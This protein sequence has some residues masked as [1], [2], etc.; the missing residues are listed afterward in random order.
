MMIKLSPYHEIFFNEWKLNPNRSD[1]NIVIDNDLFGV[2]DPIRLREALRRLSADYLLLHSHIAETAVGFCWVAQPEITSAFDYVDAPLSEAELFSY[3]KMPF[4]LE[5]GPLLRVCLI[6]IKKKH[7]RMI[8]VAHHLIMDGAKVKFIFETIPLYYNDDKHQFG[9]DISTQHQK[10]NTLSRCLENELAV[11]EEGHIKFWRAQLSGLSGADIRFLKKAQVVSQEKIPNNPIGE[12]LFSLD[13]ATD[14]DLRLLSK[15]YGT[16][17]YLFSQAIFATLL[18]RYTAQNK[19]ALC[20]LVGLPEGADFIY[21]VHVSPVIIPYQFSDD[22][23]FTDILKNAKNY[24]KRVKA[25][26]HQYFPIQRLLSDFSHNNLLTIGFTQTDLK[27]RK[28]NFDG[29]FDAS[30]NTGLNIDCSGKLLFAQEDRDGTHHYRVMYDKRYI[31]AGLLEEFIK[32]YKKLFARITGSF[33]KNNTEKPLTY[34]FENFF[35]YPKSVF[36]ELNK[37]TLDCSANQTLHQLFEER[38]R[39]IPD[40]IALV[41][42]NTKLTYRALNETANRLAHTLKNQYL[43]EPDNRIGLCLNRDSS[44]IVAVLAILKTGAAYVPIDPDYPD[45]RIQYILND[46]QARCVVTNECFEARLTQLFD[47]N[48]LGVF[49]IDAAQNQLTL[50]MQPP[51]N[52][53]TNTALNHLAYVIYTSGTTGQPKGVMIEHRSVINLV[54]AQAARFEMLD[55]YMHCLSVAP[56]VFDAHVSEIFVPLCYGHRVHLASDSLRKDMLQLS[57]YIKSNR[58]DI[59]TIP[60]AL[61]NKSY[62]LPLKILIVA[63]EKAE[64]SIVDWYLENGVK[65]INGYGP[66]E[67]TVCVTSHSYQ[68]GDIAANIGKPLANTQVYVLDAQLHLLPTSAIGELYIGGI[69]LARGYL[70]KPELTAQKF[71]PNPFQDELENGQ[72]FSGRLYKT[73]DLVRCLANG[74]L[75][76]LGRMDDQIKVRGMRV[77]LAEIENQLVH[78]PAIHTAVVINQSDDRKLLIAY[79]VSCVQ[80]EESKLYSYLSEKLPVHMLPHAFIHMQALPVTLQG[81]LDKAALPQP[82]VSPN[83]RY[84]APQNEL[85]NIVCCVYADILGLPKAAVGIDHDFFELGGDSIAAIRLVA[86][87]S[88]YLKVRINHIFEFKTPKKLIANLSIS[89]NSFENNIEN[90]KAM[91]ANTVQFF[92]NDWTVSER[93]NLGKKEVEYR[94]RINSIKFK[95]KIKNIEGVLLTGSTGHLGCNLLEKLLFETNYHIYLPVRADSQALAYDR[96]SRKF[97]YYF[98]CDLRE[99]YHHR[100]TLFASDLGEANLG[101]CD[102]DYQRL[103]DHVDSIIHCAALIKHQGACQDFYR[104]NVQAT[105]NLLE[106]AKLTRTKDFHYI[107]T[108]SVLLLGHVPNKK[109]FFFTEEDDAQILVHSKNNYVKT[110]HQAEILIGQYRGEGVQGNIYRVGNQGMHSVTHKWQENDQDSMFFSHIKAMI[111]FGEIPVEISRFEISPVD[112]TALAIVRLFRQEDIKNQIHHVFSPYA[113]DLREVLSGFPEFNFRESTLDEF[114]KKIYAKIQTNFAFTQSHVLMVYQAL[115][116]E[117]ENIYPTKIR[118][119]Q[120]KTQ[121]YLSKLNFAWPVITAMMFFEYIRNTRS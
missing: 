54:H 81:K 113:C 119:S 92:E 8:I 95:E 17:P 88:V 36:F 110:K 5:A 64:Q 9:L 85:E 24:V 70:N 23:K 31:D 44:L 33:I 80:I 2:I 35:D 1:Y 27:S 86:K 100:I 120:E 71:I 58:I 103:M 15:R 37:T 46:T 28:L 14:Q 4:N 72:Q 66:T 29:I 22:L 26:R 47:N 52:P 74:D 114:V 96:L 41:Y 75:E 7:F 42:E 49:A 10:L 13:R 90:I 57:N 25:G 87:L 11:N 38:A 20:Y 34:F 76:Y 102:A 77:E 61:L 60:P 62:F 101:L 89:K 67:A 68:V 82:A 21:G 16:T 84:T 79:Y 48:A 59:A 39:L 111:E 56:F 6:K 12:Y 99:K 91:Y 30:I 53:K 69:C 40:Q 105:K 93:I 73:G 50:H 65:V 116:Q 83:Q 18:Y 104:E 51:Q 94:A 19:F 32:K 3:A 106:L 98:N 117:M 97:F 78:Y 55:I 118:V 63:G 109:E 108:I 45:S 115:V 112:L 43:L 121:F 107:S